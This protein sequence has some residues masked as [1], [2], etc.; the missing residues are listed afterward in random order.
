MNKIYLVYEWDRCD[1][2]CEH[3]VFFET[4][5]E[6]EERVESL[7]ELYGRTYIIEEIQRGIK[8]EKCLFK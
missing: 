6:A 7:E 3:L 4:E 8:G 2:T 5:K 1:R